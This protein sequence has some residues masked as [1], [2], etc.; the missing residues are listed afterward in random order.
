MSTDYDKHKAEVARH[1]REVEQSAQATALAAE[2]AA[3]I[4]VS[5]RHDQNESLQ[6]QEALIET[7]NFRNTILLALPLVQKD[8]RNLYIM[9]QIKTRIENI[10]PEGLY[11]NK[12]EFLRAIGIDLIIETEG[13]KIEKTDNFNLMMKSA[14]N[15]KTNL[16]QSSKLTDCL[17]YQTKYFSEKENAVK[18]ATSYKNLAIVLLLLIHFLFFGILISESRTAGVAG[19]VYLLTTSI[20]LMILVNRVKNIDKVKKNINDEET[21]FEKRAE[22]KSKFMSLMQVQIKIIRQNELSAI[23]GMVFDYTVKNKIHDE[24][25]FIPPDML[26]SDNDWKENII[27]Q[28]T[29]SKIN[30]YLT[31]LEKD[32]SD[33]TYIAA[34]EDFSLLN[35][36]SVFHM[37]YGMFPL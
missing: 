16:F 29:I 17:Y 36:P 31:D 11:I 4:A 3:Q 20:P 32:V 6:R 28:K 10:K 30:E 15:L 14:I 18:S 8:Q 35:I 19:I 23:L 27:T 12:H 37:G 24:Q 1:R 9:N 34:P 25:S 13:L 21:L 5:A 2:R 33:Y 26:P 7:N 22:V